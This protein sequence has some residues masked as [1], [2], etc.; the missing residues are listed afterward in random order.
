MALLRYERDERMPEK[1]MADA[2][3]ERLGIEPYQFEFVLSDDEFHKIMLQKKI[4]NFIWNGDFEEAKAGL[5]KYKES[6]RGCRRL[7]MQYV[8]LKEGEI[9]KEQG[10]ARLSTEKFQAAMECSGME[11]AILE[12][13]NSVLLSN[14][15]MELLFQQAESLYLIEET[16]RSCH[17]F[18][19]L[20]RYMEECFW[21]NEKRAMY[22]PH[23]LYRM[24]EFTYI[25]KNFELA[26]K[27]L[28]KAREEMVREY[29]LWDLYEVL[30]LLK[31]IRGKLGRE[32]VRE[33][34]DFMTAL[35]LVNMIHGGEL[36]EEG[37]LLWEDTADK[38]LCGE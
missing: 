24:A 38:R 36:T 10:D 6:I 25:N 13:K 33:D 28:E 1:I 26:E 29:Q 14:T 12:T 31:E 18:E 15:E 23:I 34:E 8:L 21:D 7:H 30:A 27:M 19:I 20:K 22:Y 9:A 3:L 2:L 11:K 16:G 4:E 37:I 5:G 35:K 32:F 17:L